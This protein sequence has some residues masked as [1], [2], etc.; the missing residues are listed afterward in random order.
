MGKSSPED[1]QA[2][3]DAL[4]GETTVVLGSSIDEKGRINFLTIPELKGN[5]VSGFVN[6]LS[7]DDGVS[8]RGLIYLKEESKPFSGF[9]SWDM[10]ILRIAKRINLDTFSDRKNIISFQ[11]F[12]AEKWVIPADPETKSFYINFR[13]DAPRFK[14][15]SFYR[16]LEGDF[17]PEDVRDKIVLVGISSP[18][19]GD[20]HN[21]PIG[22]IPG[23]ILKANTF[24]TLYVHD[25][26]REIPKGIGLVLVFL[27]ILFTVFAVF[28]LKNWQV[29]ILIASQIVIF[30]LA[31][32]LLLLFGYV[33]D[34]ATFLQCIIT[35]YLFLLAG[36]RLLSALAL[37]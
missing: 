14:G 28:F 4:L 19:L 27:G 1:D 34:Y 18:L 23:I 30:F 6:V 5:S 8:R 20:F 25:F 22:V 24:L 9:L 12:S 33:W 11:S 35:I 21:T 32:Y 2:L 16:V 7:D 31:S 37:R 36:R 17:N 10:E 26:L 13:A 15:L 3:K 29:F